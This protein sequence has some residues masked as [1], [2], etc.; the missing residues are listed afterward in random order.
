MHRLE[1]LVGVGSGAGAV[2][3]R[4][5]LSGS[6][7]FLRECLTSRTVDP[8]PAPATSNA[9]CGFPALRFPDGFTSRVMRPIVLAALSLLGCDEDRSHRRGP[10]FRTAKSYST[11][12]SRSPGASE[13]PRRLS[14][15][16]DVDPPSQILQIN[17]RL[18]HLALASPCR[19]R[20]TISRVPSLHQRYPASSL[21]RTHPPPSRLRSISRCR[22][23]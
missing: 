13:A 8:F 23:L 2:P 6:P 14:L 18:C 9:A 21:L 22:R 17:G 10:A 11:C 12:S 20:N 7:R 5:G 19:R 15:R 1:M 16:L 4:P 3:R